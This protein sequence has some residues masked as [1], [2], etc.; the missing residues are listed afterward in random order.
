M[1]FCNL[2]DLFFLPALDGVKVLNFQV[3]KASQMRLCVKAVGDSV[4]ES[5][6]VMKYHNEISLLLQCDSPPIAFILC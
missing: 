4:V 3:R 1:Q 2:L 6:K 5:S